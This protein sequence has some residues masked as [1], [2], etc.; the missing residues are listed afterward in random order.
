MLRL[1][2]VIERLSKNPDYE[3]ISAEDAD[4]QGKRK[5][6]RSKSE[7]GLFGN[8]QD[9]VKRCQIVETKLEQTEIRLQLKV[10]TYFMKYL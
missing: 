10:F 1:C 4:K 3:Y 9:V 6:T 5:H 8:Q 7:S 2:R